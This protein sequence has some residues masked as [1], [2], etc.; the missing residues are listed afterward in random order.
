MHPLIRTALYLI[1]LYQ[2]TSDHTLRNGLMSAS[3]QAAR[4]ALPASTTASTP[5]LL[6]AA[7]R[8]HLIV[9]VP[10]RHQA[11]HSARSQ[12]NICHGCKKAFSRLDAL[13]V[14]P[15]LNIKERFRT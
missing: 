3:G 1:T 4:R 5:G 10:R 2:V 8:D 7:A 14:R 13:N 15:D 9:Y 12:T 6:A 11:L